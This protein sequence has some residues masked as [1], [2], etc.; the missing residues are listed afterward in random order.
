MP[1]IR[2]ADRHAA[3]P[4]DGE[5]A[6]VGAVGPRRTPAPAHRPTGGLPLGNGDRAIMVGVVRSKRA[7]ARGTGP[8]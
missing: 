2:R 5:S 7:S 1:G 3:R 6:L 4:F 8:G